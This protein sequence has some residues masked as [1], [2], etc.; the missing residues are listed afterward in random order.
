MIDISDLPGVFF[1]FF[2]GIIHTKTRREKREKSSL[3]LGVSEVAFGQELMSFCVPTYL[4]TE[5][6]VEPHKVKQRSFI[7]KPRLFSLT[8]SHDLTYLAVPNCPCFYLPLPS[9]PCIPYLQQKESTS[10]C[11]HKA[12]KSPSPSSSSPPPPSAPSPSPQTS[13]YSPPPPPSSPS[14]SSYP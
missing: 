7:S 3:E 12:S 14:P 6:H 13:S 5:L 4:S 1:F 8:G 11:K 2:A 9:H 10:T